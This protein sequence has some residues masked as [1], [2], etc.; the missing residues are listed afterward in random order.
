MITPRI[1]A[2]R[3]L[4][5]IAVG[6]V[7]GI[8]YSFLRPLGSR[9]RHLADFLFVSALVPAWVYYSFAVCDGD[10]RPG[11]WP[12]LFLGGWLTDRTV[13]RLLRPVWATFWQIIGW[14]YQKIKKFFLKLKIFCKK[15]F[16]DAKKLITKTTRS[17]KQIASDCGYTSNAYFSSRFKEMY[18]ITPMNMR[19]KV[20][21]D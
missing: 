13:G 19:K 9:R 10:L 1:A 21:S 15:I 3:F 17:I 14:I 20:H 4:G 7:L 16:T 6:G 5:G 18:G 12:S 2:V 8:L 11:Y